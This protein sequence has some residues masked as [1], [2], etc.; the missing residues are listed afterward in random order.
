MVIHWTTYLKTAIVNSFGGPQ[1]GPPASGGALVF[2][3]VC[4]GDDMIGII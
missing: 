1:A 2:G 4:D 3:H